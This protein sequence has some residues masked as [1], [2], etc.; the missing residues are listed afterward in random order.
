MKRMQSTKKS[1]FFTS[2]LR[3]SQ[4][5]ILKILFHYELNKNTN[6]IEIQCRNRFRN[7]KA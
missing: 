5:N 6:L 2:K 1:L 4:K 7:A 3:N